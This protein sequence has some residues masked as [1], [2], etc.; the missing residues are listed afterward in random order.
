MW[1]SQL[2]IAQNSYSWNSRYFKSSQKNTWKRI[3]NSVVNF[4]TSVRRYLKHS[5]QTWEIAADLS[6]HI[7]RYHGRDMFYS[8]FFKRDRRR[9]L[10][11]IFSSF[12]FSFFFF[13]RCTKVRG[14][15]T[16]RALSDIW[17]I[18]ICVITTD[19]FLF[20][21]TSRIPLVST[22][23]HL[24]TRATSPKSFSDIYL[25]G[26]KPIQMRPHFVEF[27]CRRLAKPLRVR[28]IKLAD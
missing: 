22:C 17:P 9:D 4:I 20:L 18:P 27:A 15:E 6:D 10:I 24:A 5:S 28:L 11:F 16:F 8:C 19:R 14:I 3:K 1:Y 13:V 26:L 12:F 7:F 25:M 21:C 23:Q 2:C